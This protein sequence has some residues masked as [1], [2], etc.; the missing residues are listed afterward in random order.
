MV[1]KNFYNFE[2]FEKGITTKKSCYI[3]Y[4]WIPE[5]TIPMASKIIKFLNISED[6][7]VLDFGCSKG[8]MVKAF[9]LLDVKA[10]G[11]DISNYA[12]DRVDPEVKNYCKLI[13]NNNYVPIKKNFSWVISKDVLEH[14]SVQQINKFLESYS[15]LC[16]KMFHVI[17]LGDNNKF[18]I[19]EYHLDKSHK[20]M[21][22]EKWWIN[23]FK[24]KGWNTID[25][26]YSV[27][28]IKDNWFETNQK[29]NGFFTLQKI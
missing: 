5:L 13:S 29:G 8:Y 3:N 12:I 14:L 4:R 19:K 17:P 6:E 20:Q 1:K 11:V 23:I 18:R 15:I 24:K 28:G 10:Y 16:K 9:R 7:N 22:N 2:Y 21:K 25:F 27:K 26:K